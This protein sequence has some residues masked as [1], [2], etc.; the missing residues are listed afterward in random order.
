MGPDRIHRALGIRGQLY[1]HSAQWSGGVDSGE[2]YG[3]FGAGVD[4]VS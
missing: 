1:E 2:E 4:T 3:E